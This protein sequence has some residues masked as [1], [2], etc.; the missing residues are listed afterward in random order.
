MVT[1][2]T[3]FP[4]SG[5]S[6]FSID[7]IYNVM[8]KNH[9][10]S[11][12]IEVIYT[13]INGIKLDE[14]PQN[15]IQLKKLNVDDFYNYLKESHALYDLH[16]N[17]DNVDEHL[18]E[19]SKEHGYFNCLIVFDECHDFLANQDK[20]KIYWLTYHRHLHHEI[21]LLTQNK[22]LVNSKYRAIPEIFIEAQPRSKK[23][24][25]STLAYKHYATFA[26]RKSDM[27]N[28]SSI[29]T[30]KEV[31][32]LYTSGNTS[33]QKSILTKFIYIAL[34]GLVLTVAIF[35][36]IFKSLE[37][38]NEEEIKESQKSQTI[39]KQPVV[40]PKHNVKHV[41][42]LNEDNYVIKIE[43]NS[44]DGYYIYDSYYSI[45]HFRK[46]IKETDS[47]VLSKYTKIS[48]KNFTLREMYIRTT[49]EDLQQFFI[50][51]QEDSKQE[52]LNDLNIKL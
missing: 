35:T 22:G 45:Q 37:V 19:H 40:N 32:D 7:K 52:Q 3:G 17:S 4:G 34:L 18:I 48:N 26:M 9:Q 49:K 11:K 33:K 20:I 28:K 38:E 5:K 36:Y 25:S 39:H 1:F 30:R 27:F 42:S 8:S 43:F 24:F 41:E 16:K 14:F 29:K 10:L 31:F 13:N 12:N 47:K 51:P 21:D 50:L 44:K 15:G 6:Y 2:I 23:L 46:F